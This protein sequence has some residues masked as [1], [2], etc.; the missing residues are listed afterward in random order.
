MSNTS[1]NF[2]DSKVLGHPAGL[3][4]LFF[5]EMWERFSYYG[6]RALLVLF[7][8][9][10]LT[11]LNPGWEWSTEAALSLLGTYALMVYLTPIA[12]GYLADKYLGYRNAVVIGAL[13]M[14]LGHASMALETE[15]FLYL[16]IAFL[17]LG[18]GFFKPN[19]TSIISY[20]YEGHED[21]KDG[22]Y[23]IF[24]MGVNAGAF[25][26]IMLCGY[27]GEKIGWS[28]GFGLA[29]IFMFL[30]MLQFYF[31]QVLFGSIGAKPSERHEVE[32]AGREETSFP[33][34]QEPAKEEQLNP[35]NIL[36]YSLIGLFLLGALIYI[37]NDPLSKI[38]DIQTLNFEILGLPDSYFF[39][40]LAAG[41]FI[42]LLAVRIP[43]YTKI[44]RDRMIA[45]VIFSLLTVFFWAAF[46]QAAGTLP[47]YTRDFTARVLSGSGATIFKI[48]DLLV[49]VVPL[50]II[51]YV[52]YALFRKTYSKIPLSNVILGS[53]FVII[54]GIVGYKV[55]AEF[56]ST[57]AEV[58]VTWFAILNS[59][60]IIT[61]APLFSRLWESKY[62]P[63]GAIKYAMGMVLLGVGFGFLA[64][65]ARNVAPGAEAAQLS[66]FWLIAAYLFHTLGE[67]CLSPMGLSYLSK[68][69]PPRMIAF[70]FGV[71]Y[72]AIAIGNKIAH[73]FGGNI[74]SIA[75][76]NGLSYFFLILT[77]IPIA[78][79]I[80]SAL[81]NP[82][83]KRLMHGVR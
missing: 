26:G 40:A 68:L 82:L 77:L 43:R 37:I 80:L 38:G 39:A 9:A 22:A 79:G 11:G 46:E 66:M 33:A 36:D 8:T 2:F 60:F 50:I 69:V 15:F 19:M 25:L 70:M 67:L 74:D 76:E 10:S 41:A 62:N 16:G 34:D 1:T 17:I 31:A 54:W 81:L 4:V 71:Y 49:T 61:F 20:M 6:M 56:Q 13:L 30:G 24:Y 58:P 28:W 83:L 53:S 14:T 45:V 65:G 52:L 42:I 57:E 63:P 59:L 3:F 64:F 78:L 5:T 27:V 7:L 47:L 32:I 48:V 23:T 18:N 44:V 21:K 73:N 29:G 72:L 12:G 55:V 75:E 51:T 35:F